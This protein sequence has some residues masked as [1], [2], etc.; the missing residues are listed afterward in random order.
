MKD[1]DENNRITANNMAN[2]LDITLP[3]LTPRQREAILLRLESKTYREMAEIMDITVRA[4]WELINGNA[5][6]QGGAHRKMKKIVKIS[7]M[8]F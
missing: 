1:R 7:K 6:K 5:K 3:R 8:K 4:A 2:L